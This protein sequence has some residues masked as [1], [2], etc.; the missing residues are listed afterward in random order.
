[1][2]HFT[3]FYLFFFVALLQ[4]ALALQ[5]QTGGI[6]GLVLDEEGLGVI[7]ANVLLDGHPGKGAVTD[8]DGRFSLS[9]LEPGT[10]GI[11]I[12]YISYQKKSVSGIVVNDQVVQL[13]AIKLAE[14]AVEMNA[15][16]VTAKALRNT[17][18]A[19]QTLQ[20]K[21]LVPVDGISS[22]TFSANGDGTAGAAMKRVT[23]VSVEGGKYVF[24]RGL[25]GRYSL[26]TLNG[27][28]IP[29][30]DPDR[31]SVQMDMFPTNILDNILV[32]K[33]FA[34][35]L[36]GSFTGGLVDI[37]TRDF[38]SERSI[39]WSVKLG[40]NPQV[41]FNQ[42]FLTHQGGT[43]DW[44]GVDDGLRQIPQ[45]ILEA[46]DIHLT[47]AYASTRPDQAGA[48]VRSFNNKTMEPSAA[49]PMP[50]MGLSFSF[51]DQVDVLGKPLGFI[52]ALTYSRN[53]SFY[54]GGDYGRFLYI[55]AGADS[56]GRDEVFDVSRSTENVLLG[57]ILSAT[58]KL[59]HFNKIG[60][61]LLHNGSGT[62]ETREQGGYVHSE[63]LGYQERLLAFTQRGV[64]TLQ[65]HG[66]HAFGESRQYQ[67]LWAGSYSRSNMSQ[68]DLRFLNNAYEDLADGERA[69]AI[70][71]A[72]GLVPTRYWRNMR[73]QTSAGKV[74]VSRSFSNWTGKKAKVKVGGAYDYKA[75][76]FDEYIYQFESLST[77]FSGDFN[78]YFSD[79]HVISEQNLS[80]IY[81][82]DVSNPK[83]TY[84]ASSYVLGAYAMAEMPLTAS[85]RMVGGLRAEKAGISF[86]GYEDALPVSLLDDLDL[87][88]AAGMIYEWVPDKMNLR[89][90]YNRTVARPVFREISD[91]AFFDF[92]NNN[93]LL[94]NPGLKRTRI[95]NLDMRWEYFIS[96]G[97]KIVFSVFYKDFTSPIELAN[98]PE[99]KNGEWVFQ[100]VDFARVSGVEIEV[101]KRLTFVNA[102][103]DLSVGGNLSL[104]RSMAGIPASELEN[105]RFHEPEAPA[106]RP[107]FGQAPYLVNAFVS[108]GNEKGMQAQ[109][110]YNVQGPRLFLVQ[111]G[112][113]P[114]VYEQPFHQLNLTF[115]RRLGQFAL[116][117]GAE[118]L[119]NSTR[120]RSITYR[121]RE[122]VFQA[123][124][125]GRRFSVGL[126]YEL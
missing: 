32:Y 107:L 45:A 31:N 22:Q 16:L 75:R 67:L 100:N 33:A 66:S 73:E 102:L 12:S 122:Y 82:T 51:G 86:Q 43:L 62:R 44:L 78:D 14:A 89:F 112:A 97:E 58:Y 85:L 72:I 71:P 49:A 114:D 106:V 25:G 26:T 88:P 121:N 64:S 99:A 42:R 3:R 95:D 98:N 68:P 83:N 55:S 119:L 115:S 27:L 118:N 10:Y 6:E 74:N 47:S 59:N 4:G 77:A 65:L 39:R 20:R 109:L 46:E 123:F 116:S 79:E 103:R 35:D 48:L 19:I 9:G 69:Y 110:S 7:G 70:L 18:T 28:S 120:K 111:V 125:P 54:E 30:L 90:S 101:R 1:M 41:H 117:F 40:Y 76:N 17:E 56:L 11:T 5:A 60:I 91:V 80:G 57:G 126:S 34:P 84:Y 104:I 93:F 124:Q 38:P 96:A 92:L 105:I 52:L 50:D 61:T 113:M 87:L 29:G 8:V 24:V 108:Y 2:K 37:R 81:V 23:G 53:Y 36:P 13:G 21:S 94:G 15:V 63:N